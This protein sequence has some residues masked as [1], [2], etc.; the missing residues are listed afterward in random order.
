MQGRHV[1]KADLVSGAGSSRMMRPFYSKVVRPSYSPAEQA[2]RLW[3][4]SRSAARCKVTVSSRQKS[5]QLGIM[6]VCA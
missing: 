5:M 4:M 3:L 2:L 1:I 6:H